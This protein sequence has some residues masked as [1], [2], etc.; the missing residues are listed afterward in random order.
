MSVSLE[1]KSN[2]MAILDEEVPDELLAVIPAFITLASRVGDAVEQQGEA[3]EYCDRLFITLLLHRQRVLPALPA[4]VLSELHALARKCVE[5]R[6][7]NC[8]T[9]AARMLQQLGHPEDAALIEANRPDYSPILAEVFDDIAR[10]LRSRPP[11]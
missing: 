7:P 10:A 4:G 9:R 6:V 11:A 3:A 1:L 2:A 8:S 5:A